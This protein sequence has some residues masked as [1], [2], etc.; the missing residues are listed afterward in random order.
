M[1]YIIGHTKPDLDSAVAAIQQRFTISMIGAVAETNTAVNM[2]IEGVGASDY[3][4]GTQD[5]AAEL[6]AETGFTVTETVL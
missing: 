5:I 6:S 4:D 1:I 2:I 3:I